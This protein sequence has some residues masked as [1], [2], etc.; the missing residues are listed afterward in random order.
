MHMVN[1]VKCSIENIA[2]EIWELLTYLDL[3]RLRMRFLP[4]SAT[5]LWTPIRLESYDRERI[6]TLFPM[7]SGSHF[8][9][10]HM[11]SFLPSVVVDVHVSFHSSFPNAMPWKKMMTKSGFGEMHFGLRSCT[12]IIYTLEHNGQCIFQNSHQ[13]S[14]HDH[15]TP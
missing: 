9:G 14:I 15:Q 11:G 12:G 5:L 7:S 4:I 1:L 13:C 3:T 6:R 2:K 8:S 10:Q